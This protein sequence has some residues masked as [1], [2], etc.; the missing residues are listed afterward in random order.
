MVGHDGDVRLALEN[1]HGK[2]GQ[3]SLGPYFDENS[4]ACGVH[5]LDLFG[6]LDRRRHL[7]CQFF[8]DGGLRICSLN[9]VER[10]VDV[11]RDGDFRP[12]Y[13]QAL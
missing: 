11:R 13:F 1:L 5:R 12:A 10:P 4:S 2:H 8:Q 3:G 9:G 6:P 7:R